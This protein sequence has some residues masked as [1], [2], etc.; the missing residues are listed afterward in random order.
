MYGNSET[1][2]LQLY[3]PFVQPSD[4][5]YCRL[6]AGRGAKD[7]DKDDSDIKNGCVSRGIFPENIDDLKVITIDIIITIIILLHLLMLK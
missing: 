4:I 1:S 3:R 5:P 2:L 6:A 7:K